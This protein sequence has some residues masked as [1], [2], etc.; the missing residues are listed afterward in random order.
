MRALESKTDSLW[1]CL[2]VGVH[3]FPVFVE[4][5]CSSSFCTGKHEFVCFYVCV[6]AHACQYP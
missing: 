5:K 1:V 2:F 3:S 4:S 6:Q